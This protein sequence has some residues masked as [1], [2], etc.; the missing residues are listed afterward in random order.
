MASHRPL[1][2]EDVAA[3]LAK[4]EE[5]RNTI[6]VGGQAL[7]IFAVYYH[8]EAATS[9]VSEDI[10]F[11][12]DRSVAVAAGKAW[13]GETRLAT[14]DD[15]TP[16]SAAVI[17]EIDGASHQIDFMFSLLGIDM[18]EMQPRERHRHLDPL[19]RASIATAQQRRLASRLG[20]PEIGRASC[21]ERV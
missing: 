13:G 14:M 16:N 2:L 7:N 12:G 1:G 6:L 17:V 15:A 3:L 21:R 20:Q 18:D 4:S 9:A 8:C 10:D 5:T 19:L 11:F